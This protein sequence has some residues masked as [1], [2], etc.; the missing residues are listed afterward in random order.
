MAISYNNC[1]AQQSILDGFIFTGEFYDCLAYSQIEILINNTSA[2]NNYDLTIQFSHDKSIVLFEETVNYINILKNVIN[3]APHGKF[4]KIILTANSDID[5]L[6]VNTTLKIN[7][8]YEATNDVVDNVNI[9]SSV[10]VEVI[11]KE[12]QY[13][14]NATVATNVAQVYA[15]GAQ[16]ANVNGGWLYI[17]RLGSPN[18]INWYVYGNTAEQPTTAKRIKDI[19]DMYAIIYQ[20]ETIITPKTN[21]FIAFYSLMDAGTNNGVFYK[22]RFVFANYYE[23]N[24]VIG[25]KLLYI[26]ANN[27]LIH[28]EITTRVQLNYSA[29]SSTSTLEASENELLYLSSLQTDSAAAEAGVYNFVFSELGINFNED[30]LNAIVMPIIDNKVQI[31]GTVAVS[32]CTLPTGA[33]TQ[34]TL[35]LINT[36]TPALGQADAT[37]STPVVL[38]TAQITALTVGLT[39]TQLRASAIA[40]S[41]TNASTETTLALIKA[42]TDNIPPLI[43]GSVPVAIRNAIPLAT[44]NTIT[45]FYA[46]IG[47]WYNIFDVGTTP[48]AVWVTMGATM[49]VLG[50]PTVGTCFRCLA[51]GSGTGQISRLL[52]NENVKISPTILNYSSPLQGG[53]SSA[54]IVVASTPTVMR[55]IQL[56]NIGLVTTYVYLYN[57]A[58]AASS[59]DTPLFIYAVLPATSG[60]NI[61]INHFFQLGISMRA[62]SDYNGT[63]SPLT[64]TFSNLT[65][66]AYNGNLNT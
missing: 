64:E 31:A 15:D 12:P 50:M 29:I 14:F 28:P 24:N 58:S 17:N 65:L 42:K 54:G 37:L 23:T 59:A 8:I 4:I 2:I 41:T 3:R 22:N 33:A 63:T 55:N 46:E 45:V 5:D 35:A 19:K 18:K 32:S 56:T 26:G 10:G 57:K 21:P 16:G 49:T 11:G 60:L 66:T 27:P 13:V 36:K 20:N 43:S 44:V 62:T 7:N 47:Q 25:T 40:V 9:V 48:L 53:L 30:A 1:F 34:T 6:N 52:Y 39:N 38:P 51:K 61:D